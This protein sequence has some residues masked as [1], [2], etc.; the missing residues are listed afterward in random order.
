[1]YFKHFRNTT[2]SQW[3]VKDITQRVAFFEELQKDELNASDYIVQDG[4]TPESLAQDF[5]DN[6]EYFWIILHMNSMID[7][8]YDWVMS[9]NTF[10]RYMRKKYP[11]PEAIKEWVLPDGRRFP[12]DPNDGLNFTGLQALARPVTFRYY[13][14]LINEAKRNIRIL[15]PSSLPKVLEQYTML[16]R[17]T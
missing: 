15:R 4:E 12:A 13:E 8:F 2:H 1:M 5:Y 16:M 10:E 7:P 17:N 9:T 14:E 3:D 11:N 6:S